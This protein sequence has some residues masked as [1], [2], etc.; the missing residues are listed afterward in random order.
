MD[1]LESLSRDQIE[2]QIEIETRYC[3]WRHPTGYGTR[4]PDFVFDT[5]PYVDLLLGD[6]NL[7]KHRMG[8]VISEIFGSYGAEDYRGLVEEWKATIDSSE[9]LAKENVVAS[10]KHG[11]DFHRVLWSHRSSFRSR[12]LIKIIFAG[13]EQYS[14]A[15]VIISKFAE[16]GCPMQSDQNSPF[17]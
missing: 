16:V 10:G 13:V 11:T 1:S 7:V 9:L 14:F 17:R 4:F 12:W 8:D 6:L 2:W 3:R 5:V 15:Q